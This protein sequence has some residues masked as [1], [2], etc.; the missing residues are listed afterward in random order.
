M[1]LIRRKLLGQDFKKVHHSILLLTFIIC[2]VYEQ[3]TVPGATLNSLVYWP[4]SYFLMLWLLTGF[5]PI[6]FLHGL[7][8]DNQK[9]ISYHTILALLFGFTHVALSD[10]SIVLLERLLNIPEHLALGSLAS[11]WLNAWQESLKSSIWYLVTLAGISILYYRELYKNEQK[12]NEQ[13][14]QRL[15]RAEVKTLSAEL[16]PHFLFNAMNGI[17]MQVR[18]N[19]SQQAIESIANLG[20]MLRAVLN[21]RNNVFITV[22]EELKLLDR[23]ISLEKR[24]FK[25]R[26]IIEVNCENKVLGSIIP[27]L[28][29]Q[30]IVE[31]A[32]KHGVNADPGESKILVNV[33]AHVDKLCIE[34][35]N[36][37]TS[38]ITWPMQKSNSIGL[39]NTVER[40]RKLYKNNFVL[41]IKQG[42]NGIL[43]K[44]E[45]P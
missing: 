10:I 40:L 37:G 36:T 14:V 20:E 42:T 23:Y 39:P 19:E 22:E 1:L 27:K 28:L 25:E 21:T 29:L 13:L 44:I 45:L 26:I 5:I 9:A 8:M 32:F 2:V 24:R 15:E 35:F 4:L 3:I 7:T 41:L 30:P 6:L 18:K 43:V 12:K 17:A 38:R 34:V 31:N 33:F 11:K 16:N